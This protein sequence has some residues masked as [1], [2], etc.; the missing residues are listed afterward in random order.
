MTFI[1]MNSMNVR[2][3]VQL[4]GLTVPTIKAKHGNNIP[5]F[6]ATGVT[7][8]FRLHSSTVLSR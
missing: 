5:Y 6:N 8:S 1:A 4:G 7:D 3:V 2:Y